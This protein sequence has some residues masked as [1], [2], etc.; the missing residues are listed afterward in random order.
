VLPVELCEFLCLRVP[1]IASFILTLLTSVFC[2]KLFASLGGEKLLG[3]NV[4]AS[5]VQCKKPSPGEPHLVCHYR[6]L[7]G[8]SL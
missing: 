6:E 4:E 2:R 1:G 7:V 8:N 5:L 3:T